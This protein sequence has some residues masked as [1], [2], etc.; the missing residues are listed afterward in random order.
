MWRLIPGAE[1]SS[2]RAK[3]NCGAPNASRTS[4]NGSPTEMPAITGA[5]ERPSKSRRPD[6]PCSHS[7]SAGY[8][9][10]NASPSNVR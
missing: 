10:A 6:A 2:S 3:P 5:V 1:R 9:A 4:S 7:A 8:F